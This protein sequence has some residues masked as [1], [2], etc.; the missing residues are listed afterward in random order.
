MV[1]NFGSY[2]KHERELR[3]VPLEEISGT[4]K[5][6]IRFLKALEENSFDQLPGEV[7]IKGYIRSYAN[8]I[9]SDGEE[10]L[11]IYKESVEFN[12]Q[13]NCPQET[14]SFNTQ[15]KTFLAYGLLI[16]VVAGFLFGVG[17]L[18]KNGIGDSSG[19]SEEKNVPL[20]QIQAAAAN[21]EPSVS[22]S[23]DLFEE[24]PVEENVDAQEEDSADLGIPELSIQINPSGKPA[25]KEDVDEKKVSPPQESIALT[26]QTTSVSQPDLESQNPAD[27]E[28]SLKLSIHVKEISWFNMTIDDLREEDF[29]L[30]AGTSKTFWG[31]E[32]IRLT[33]GNKTG[34]EL[35][36]N[37]K[38]ITLP[39]SEDKVVKDF[40]I[41]SK[42]VD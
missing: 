19:K 16:L 28:K 10:L 17:V 27:I 24:P 11:N 5:I 9:G 25:R 15:P 34:V 7:F 14:A 39:E 38:A 4:T 33:I 1:E 2:L 18:I 29:I 23:S 21:Q 26:T 13:E 12:K 22:S 35:V 31:N 3:G 20:L 8:V 37:G 6:H 30:L 40:I 32:A 41:H 36:L 42:L